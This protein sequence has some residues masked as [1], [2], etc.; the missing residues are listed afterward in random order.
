MAFCHLNNCDYELMQQ[1]KHW[2][3]GG[4]LYLSIASDGYVP[5]RNNVSE[6]EIIGQ[7]TK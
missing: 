1:W 3:A 4:G 7:E 5:F 6:L 2:E